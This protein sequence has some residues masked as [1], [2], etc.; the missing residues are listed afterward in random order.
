VAYYLLTGQ[1]V[2][3][4]DTPMKM[5]LQHVQ[6]Q[7]VPPSQRTELDIPRELDELVLACLQKDPDKRPQNAEQLFALAC[8]CQS[9][10]T[11]DQELA[12][13]WW[14]T[15]LPEFTGP[16]TVEEPMPKAAATVA[17]R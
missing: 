2:F 14:Q 4:A 8:R 6:A 16:L 11:W 1:L 5:M 15:H 10:D 12:R 13:H 9:C 17:L 7:P 3:E